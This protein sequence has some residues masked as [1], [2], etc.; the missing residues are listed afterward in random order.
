MTR[1]VLA[2]VEVT[3]SLRTAKLVIS[4]HRLPKVTDSSQK[5]MMLPFIEGGDWL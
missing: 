2:M 1:P 5:L 3:A 4:T